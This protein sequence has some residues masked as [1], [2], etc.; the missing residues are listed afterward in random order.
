V[1]KTACPSASV[2]MTRGCLSISMNCSSLFQRLSLALSLR[3]K[4]RD[5]QFSSSRPS[6]WRRWVLPQTLKAP[7]TATGTKYAATTIEDTALSPQS[8]RGA[9]GSRYRAYL[10]VRQSGETHRK[11]VGRNRSLIS[12][13][14]QPSSHADSLAPATPGFA[15]T[16]SSHSLLSQAAKHHRRCCFLTTNPWGY[17]GLESRANAPP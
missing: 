16:G 8:F 7:A 13:M 12:L 1:K 9:P 10:G 5:L 6:R 15:K 2:G 3:A 4:P 14:V 17:M 11:T